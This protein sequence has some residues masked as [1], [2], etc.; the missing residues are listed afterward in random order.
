MKKNIHMQ[1]LLFCVI[2][3]VAA[4]GFSSDTNS[5]CMDCEALKDL[6]FPDVKIL[7]SSIME[8]GTAHCRVLGRISKEIHFEILLP[9][10]WNERFL[11]SGG[12][13][14]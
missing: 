13:G 9:N 8:D 14:F 10:K 11:M 2:N 5:Y 12:G 3:A 7:E 6:E 4:F 1:I